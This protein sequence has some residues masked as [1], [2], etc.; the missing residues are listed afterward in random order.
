[1]TYQTSRS[2]STIEISEPSS[3]T[4]SLQGAVGEPDRPLFEGSL[5][6]RVDKPF[7]IIAHDGVSGVRRKLGEVKPA[8]KIR[9]RGLSLLIVLGATLGGIIAVHPYFNETN[10]NQTSAK[11]LATITT[12]E[13]AALAT[14]SANEPLVYR[15]DETK[16][17][18]VPEV[19]APSNIIEHTK[20]LAIP[21]APRQFLMAQGGTR[22]IPNRY[23]AAPTDP[24]FHR[25]TDPELVDLSNGSNRFAAENG[26]LDWQGGWNLG[27]P[28][29]NLKQGESYTEYLSSKVG[30]PFTSQLSTTT[31]RPSKL[32]PQVSRQR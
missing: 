30:S 27:D 7:E 16:A 17:V 29:A 13:I 26:A 28:A 4:P 5:R 31:Q 11:D 8:R 2:N 21:L 1:M 25:M 19:A 9:W 14:N 24:Q 18:V 20:G 10:S 15:S 3:L 22:S 12:A 32:L 6:Q 23:L